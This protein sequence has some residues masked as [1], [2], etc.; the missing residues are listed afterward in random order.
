[1]KTK[2]VLLTSLVIL[3]VLATG[4]WGGWVT[5]SYN[6]WHSYCID[7]KG[8]EVFFYVDGYPTFFVDCA[9]TDNKTIEFKARHFGIFELRGE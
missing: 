3:G 1:M 7:K 5:R 4:F 8:N 2:D 6:D 9:N